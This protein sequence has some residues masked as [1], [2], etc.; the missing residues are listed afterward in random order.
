MTTLDTEKI[1]KDFPIFKE[2]RDLIYLD[3]AASS[4]TP[5]SVLDVMNEYYTSYRANI[6]R[7]MYAA[8]EKATLEY[9]R[10]RKVLADFIG[11]GKE[12]IIFTSGATG[13]ANMLAYCMEHSF[14]FKEGDE[15]ITTI[16]EHHSSLVPLQELAHRKKMNQ[17]L[18][19]PI[20]PLQKINMKKPEVVSLMIYFSS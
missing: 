7:G 5:Q 11:A 18:L 10:S 1:K 3:N 2:N 16:A 4:Q 12:E 15:I 14:D 9:E 20:L 13:A 17:E 8:S 6:H 19:N